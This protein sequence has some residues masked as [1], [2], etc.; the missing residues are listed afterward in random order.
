VYDENK[1]LSLASL[2]DGIQRL[3]EIAVAAASSKGI[4]LFDEFENGLHWSVQPLAWKLLLELSKDL[5]VQIFATTHSW[6]CVKAFQEVAGD[7][8]ETGI[9]FH[10]GKS[11]RKSDYGQV[12]VTTYSGA[13]LR[14]ATRAGLEV[15]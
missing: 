12:L 10:L 2:G 4:I 5:G 11:V 8:D 14:A 1:R 15:R 3:F 13:E 6:D 7:D 9:L